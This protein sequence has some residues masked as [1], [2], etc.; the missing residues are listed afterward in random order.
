[1]RPR[2]S[3]GAAP[4]I[5]FRSSSPP[6][7]SPITS[8]GDGELEVF[9]KGFDRQLYRNTQAAG[10]WSGWAPIGSGLVNGPP[11]AIANPSG[12]M[13][14]FAQAEDGSLIH[15][16]YQPLLN[17]WSKENLGGP[18]KG[19]FAW[20]DKP[21][22]VEFSTRPPGS[23]DSVRRMEV[24]VRGL[25]NQ[26]YRIYWERDE[27]KWSTWQPIGGGFF[28]GAAA[29]T[30]WGDDRM[31]LV[32][33]QDRGGSA[34]SVTHGY[35][36]RD[37][38]DSYRGW[39]DLPAGAQSSP[40]IVSTGFNSLDV[41][42]Q[43]TDLGL[44]HKAWL[45]TTWQKGWDKVTN[46]MAGNLGWGRPPSAVAFPSGRID[47]VV[48][49]NDRSVWHNVYDW[50][51]DTTPGPQ[52]T[53]AECGGDGQ[54]CCD[55]RTCKPQTGLACN[56]NNLCIQPTCGHTGE[57][58]CLNSVDGTPYCTR[59][60]QCVPDGSG[61]NICQQDACGNLN[62]ICCDNM[63]CYDGSICNVTPSG[64][65]YCMTKFDPGRG[66]RSVRVVLLNQTGNRLHFADASASHGDWAGNLPGLIA[67]GAYGEWQTNSGGFMTG[68][69][70]DAHYTLEGVGDVRVH[71][72]NPFFGE[73]SYSSSAPRGYTV[74][75]SGG[76]QNHATIFF[77]LRPLSTPSNECNSAWIVNHLSEAP[78]AYLDWGKRV[79]GVISTPLGKRLHISGWGTT[80]CVTAK[81]IGTVVM[82]Q[83]ST[84][85]FYTVDIKVESF[86]L[87]N[88]TV[89]PATRYLRLEVE[90]GGTAH[91]YLNDHGANL[92]D[93]I[94]TGGPMFIDTD[95]PSGW[96]E[97]H[98]IDDFSVLP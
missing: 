57:Y 20:Y 70:G 67:P 11:T 75:S 35:W 79:T 9:G 46:C 53:C 18:T 5:S 2:C 23:S 26:L 72:D 73:N 78:Q 4:G 43:G 55:N 63:V 7:P 91:S 71:W 24:V 69:E 21:G 58:C 74:E 28:L 62:Q 60:H 84:D 13:D 54:R 96:L 45:G 6:R 14:I 16:N 22:A 51:A 3:A 42:V 31:D 90:R 81:A 87:G 52:P 61:N 82:N 88:Y 85:G 25:D 37:L 44:Y 32:A 56:E 38:G 94:E 49:S 92:G 40:D 41:F 50:L 89:T 59:H 65:Q 98:P 80:G 83:H 15:L 76:E 48:T 34:P 27:F 68:T 47:V 1:L 93:R 36:Q 97:V 19:Q 29:L 77:F 10:M 86:S 8:L 95:P 39:E 17:R 12:E 30:S 66:A 64:D 33:P